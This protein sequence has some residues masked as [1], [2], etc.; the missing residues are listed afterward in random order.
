MP[1]KKCKTGTAKNEVDSQIVHNDVVGPFK[2]AKL[3]A[4]QQ[5]DIWMVEITHLNKIQVVSDLFKMK[6][7]AIKQL[8]PEKGTGIIS[9]P[10]WDDSILSTVVTDEISPNYTCNS[11]N[12]SRESIKPCQWGN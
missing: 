10:K 2:D 7:L 3:H 6:L 8:F 9:V 11:L 4:V 1:S 12:P 5:L